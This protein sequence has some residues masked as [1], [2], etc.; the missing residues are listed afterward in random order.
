MKRAALF[1]RMN[2]LVCRE[3]HV[4]PVAVRPDVD[5]LGRGVQAPLSGWDLAFAGL[6]DW[7][8]E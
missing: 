2:D 8:R 3:G 6:H 4:L 7:Y 1:I 5:A